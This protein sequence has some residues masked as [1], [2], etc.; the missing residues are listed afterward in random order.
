MGFMNGGGSMSAPDQLLCLSGANNFRIAI[1]RL[2]NEVV[3]ITIWC[4]AFF[5][6]S[7]LYI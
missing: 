4:M 1:V 6:P 5:F 2:C 3:F 7:P